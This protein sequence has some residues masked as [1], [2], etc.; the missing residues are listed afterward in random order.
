MKLPKFL[1]KLTIIDWIII[2]CIILAICFAF[3]YVATDDNGTESTSIDPTTMSKVGQK[4][5]EYYME[6]DVVTTNI[7]GYNATNGKNL[8]I[9]GTVLWEDDDSGANTKILIESG[10]QHYLAASY[11]DVKEADI[12]ID[13]MTLEKTENKYNN[14]V[15]LTINPLSIA[16]LNELVQG[17]PNGTNYEIT[18]TVSTNHEGSQIYQNLTNQLYA[19]HERI[20]IKPLSVSLQDQIEIVRATSKEINIGNDVL[21]QIDGQT[22]QIKL[23]IYNCDNNTLQT[24][25]NNYNVT[26]VEY[27]S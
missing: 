12:Y 14:T 21:G 3:I 10:G 11:N 17:I 25:K 2:I 13:Q 22:G 20:S 24:I 16:T 7:V 6:G 15:E 5:S 1:K 18:T 26:N 27:V 8:N 23:R 4:Y 9:E 19:N